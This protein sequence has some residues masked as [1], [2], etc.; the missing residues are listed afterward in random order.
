VHP[1]RLTAIA[2]LLVMVSACAKPSP[3]A[4]PPVIP[5]PAPQPVPSP[6][7]GRVDLSDPRPFRLQRTAAPGSAGPPVDLSRFTFLSETVGFGATHHGSLV[8]TGDGGET[9]REV[10][11][12][13][14]V[15]YIRLHFA[16]D[17]NGFAIGHTD[18]PDP[19]ESCT[20]SPVLVRSQ[21]AGVTWELVKP[22]GLPPANDS[23][24]WEMRFVFLSGQVGYVAGIETGLLKTVDS[25]QT[26]RAVSLPPK[27]Q[28]T[29]GLHFLTKDQGFLSGSRSEHDHVVL[30]TNDGGD[31]WQPIWQGEVPIRAIQFLNDREGFIGG[32]QPHWRVGPTSRLLLRTKDGGRSWEEINRSDDWNQASPIIDLRMRSM[33]DGWVTQERHPML[34]SADGGQSWERSPGYKTAREMSFAG[35]RLWVWDADDTIG[36]FRAFLRRSDDAG[37]TWETLYQ[38]KALIARQIHFVSPQV[39]W[40]SS[41]AGVLRT[42]DGG[43]AW[44]MTAVNPPEIGDGLYFAGNQLL[45]AFKGRFRGGNNDLLRSLDGGR[46]WHTVAQA[47]GDQPQVVFGSPQVG[48][49]S[50]SSTQSGPDYPYPDRLLHTTDSGETWTEAAAKLPTRSVIA[51]ADE[52]HGVAVG[53]YPDLILTATADGGQTWNRV[54]LPAGIFVQS[55]SY[56]KEGHLWMTAVLHEGVLRGGYLL[57]SP[58][59]GASWEAFRLNGEPWRIHF[60]TPAMGWLIATVD[61]AHVLA[62][63]MDGGRTW[64]EIWP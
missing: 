30:T 19:R 14:G 35:D 33:Q 25:G 24:W 43:R 10:R 29:G 36:G 61:G 37:R 11:Y 40:L 15:R 64:T 53:G 9:W 31:S 5:T 1:F 41:Q 21:N 54:D 39:G 28:A 18:C 20:G 58:D 26:W 44:Q 32:G 55:I 49:L 17:Q 56:G 46:S 2:L 59:R 45:F 8:R 52:T 62:R 12:D 22:V 38:R 16:G 3:P 13:E 63:T 47:I 51:L 4:L 34:H 27:V 7:L 57:H 23:A 6:T 60:A 48:W 50:Y 42:T